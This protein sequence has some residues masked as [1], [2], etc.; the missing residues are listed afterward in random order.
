VD[1][2][3]LVRARWFSWRRQ[4][5]DRSCAGVVDCLR[6]VVGVY[7]SN[8]QGPLS[9]LARVPRLMKGAAIEGVIDTKRAVRI[10]AMR[11]S[12][13]MVATQDAPAVFAATRNA[14]PVE[15]LLRRSGIGRRLYARIRSEVLA[16]AT[17]PVSVEA[18][19]AGVTRPPRNLSVALQAMT[20]EGVLVRVGSP[21]LRANDP[22]YAATESWLGG[23]MPGVDAAEAR[24]WL[25]GG[26]LHA[27][28]PARADDFAWWSGMK[29][30]AAREAL[31][32]HDPI[33]V[34][35]GYLLHRADERA[36]AGTRPMTG[37]VN[38]LPKWD[39]YTM[40]YAPDGR[41]RFLPPAMGAAAYSAGGDAQPVILVD[42][43]V[44]GTWSI[45]FAGRSAEIT[46]DPPGRLSSRTRRALGDEARLIGSFFE[47]ARLDVRP[48]AGRTSPSRERR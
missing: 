17:A 36:F 41:A 19:R 46:L 7:S 8:P 32:T 44:R 48:S 6:S 47:V 20:A 45:R 37:R 11:G 38:L 2:D 30:A 3:T 5:L 13:F 43:M 33:D 14:T 12:V 23:P 40:G 21:S 24:A 16:A 35:G 29:A 25:A 1:R 9:L 34:G 42:G 27:F 15:W 26:Y 4:R 22:T 18:L 28:G 10:P 39:C 31:A